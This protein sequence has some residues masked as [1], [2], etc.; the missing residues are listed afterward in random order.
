MADKYDDLDR[1][2][3]EAQRSG[4]EKK[5]RAIVNEFIDEMVKDGEWFEK[6]GFIYSL[7]AHDAKLKN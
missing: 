3:R 2:W 5:I 4:D 6:D 1:R 7:E